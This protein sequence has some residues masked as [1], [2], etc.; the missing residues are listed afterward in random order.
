MDSQEHFVKCSGNE[1]AFGLKA[2]FSVGDVTKILEDP[3]FSATRFILLRRNYIKQA[4]ATLRRKECGLGQFNLRVKLEKQESPEDIQKFKQ[5]K[6]DIKPQSLVPLAK[7]YARRTD[8]LSTLRI[9]NPRRAILEVNYEDLVENETAVVDE[10]VARFL[11]VSST[12]KQ[13]SV[14]PSLQKASPDLLCMS[15]KNTPDVC[16]AVKRMPAPFLDLFNVNACPN[17]HNDST[18]KACCAPC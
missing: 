10:R 11:S 9:K 7:H 18:G 2:R 3:A 13:L 17:T 4:V 8:G 5:Q 14:A 15:M 1:T 16:S 6:C 12:R